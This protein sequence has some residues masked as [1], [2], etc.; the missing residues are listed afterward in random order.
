MSGREH[1][2][3]GDATRRRYSILISSGIP[4]IRKGDDWLTLDLWEMDLRVQAVT[5]EIVRLVCP[6]VTDAPAEWTSLNAL[7]RK[8]E[9]VRAG[10]TEAADLEALF[11]GIDVLQVRGGVSWAGFRPRPGA[12]PRRTRT[13]DQDDHRYF[14]Q[15][16]AREPQEFPAQGRDQSAAH[17]QGIV[18]I[19]EHQ[20]GGAQADGHV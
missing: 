6:V 11:R 18:A 2:P 19:H 14:Q 20:G 12:G 5:C 10:S 9:I 16:G 3:P 13:R 15:S 4:V 8:I 7:P 17:P 1:S